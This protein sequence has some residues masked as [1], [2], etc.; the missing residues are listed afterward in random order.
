MLEDSS[1]LIGTHRMVKDLDRETA[2]ISAAY[3]LTFPQFMVMEALL[4]KGPMTVG[5]IKDVILSSSGT[6]PVIINNLV[7][8]ELVIR[9]KDP[10][11]QR[12]SVVTLTEQGREL[13]EKICPENEAMYTERFSVWTKEEKKELIRLLSLYRKGLHAKE[14]ES[15]A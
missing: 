5:E 6:I 12:K 1:I 15:N 9:V 8:M 3:G 10:G 7:K 4:N 14:K 11:D 13:I 2:R